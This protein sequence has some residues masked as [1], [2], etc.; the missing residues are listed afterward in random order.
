MI[1]WPILSVVTFLPTLG[2]LLVV[3]Y[4]PRPASN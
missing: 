1:T 4:G 2:A 3:R